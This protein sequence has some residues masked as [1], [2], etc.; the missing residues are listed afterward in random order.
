MS[1]VKRR[2]NA[3]Q[4][5][6][7]NAEH[8]ARLTARANGYVPTPPHVVRWLIEGMRA[9][10]H[11]SL[12]WGSD[13]VEPMAGEGAIVFAAEQVLGPLGEWTLCELRPAACEVLRSKFWKGPLPREVVIRQG[14]YLTH[15]SGVSGVGLWISN[16]DFKVAAECLAKMRE[17]AGSEGTIALHVPWAFAA[18]DALDGL[19]V[20][21]YPIEGR[22]YKF[23]RETCWIV[24]GP[25]RGGRRYRLR[26]DK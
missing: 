3:E 1:A 17:E 7:F 6:L 4:S 8:T 18:T 14:D 9:A 13:K 21:L 23:V 15:G 10:G 16:P 20:D 5:P 22:P 26:G 2:P 24:L 19:E 25:G 12:P 11:R